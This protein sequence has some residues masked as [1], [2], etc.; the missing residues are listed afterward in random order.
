M[1][2]T[3]R[4]N[5]ELEY[6]DIELTAE[7]KEAVD[8]GI[9]NLDD[10]RMRVEMA[11]RKI[12]EALDKHPYKIFE[13]DGSWM[14]YFP[15]EEKGRV[16]KKRKNRKD[17]EKLIIDL[18]CKEE[19]NPT[20]EELFNEWNTTCLE[21]GDIK[22]STYDR[23]EDFYKRHFEE[24][25]KCRIKSINVKEWAA[26]LVNQ[27]NQHHLKRKAYDGLH[28][29]TFSLLKYAK[30]QDLIDFRITDIDEYIILGKNKFR[31]NEAKSE[32]ELQK[33]VDDM[34]EVFS[35]EDTEKILTYLMNHLDDKNLGILLMFV[36]GMRIGEV[37]ALKKVYV[38]EGG[39]I[40]VRHSETKYRNRNGEGYIYEVSEVKTDAG[41]RDVVLPEGCEWLCEMLKGLN[42]DSEFVFTNKQGRMTTNCFRRRQ[43]RICKKL[44]IT[45]KSPHK[46]RK[47]YA[48]ILSDYGFDENFKLRQMGHANISTTEENYHKDRK[49][50]SKK[51][52]MLSAITEF[53]IVKNKV[54]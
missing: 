10:V 17:L 14:T 30:T 43:E 22:N 7:L 31:N 8:Y 21:N 28:Q 16:L 19:E 54:V 15:D 25:G 53:D 46:D 29:L 2:P 5:K 36:S 24:M 50:V 20:I 52:E 39:V 26:F 9:I 38:K 40:M 37:A 11:K 41:Y 3:D 1:R 32:K 23:H 47:T 35:V 34:D 45:Q 44:N 49:T 27:V 48:T 33:S 18:Q 42:T 4:K 51:A 6:G 13:C 12:Q